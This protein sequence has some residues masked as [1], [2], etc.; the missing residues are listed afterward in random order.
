MTFHWLIYSTFKHQLCKVIGEM[1]KNQPKKEWHAWVIQLVGSWAS[2]R[3]YGIWRSQMT[4]YLCCLFVELECLVFFP[5]SNWSH[6][7]SDASGK[8]KDVF[9]FA[10]GKCLLPLATLTCL[11]S[12][13]SAF[14]DEGHKVTT[15]PHKSFVGISS[16]L[17]QLTALNHHHSGDA[18]RAGAATARHVD[19]QWWLV[20]AWM[21]PNHGEACPPCLANQKGYCGDKGMLLPLTNAYGLNMTPHQLL[22]NQ[23]RAS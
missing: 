17:C 3:I 15:A 18:R 6:W 19:S 14:P 22:L 16:Q 8:W 12:K 21:H 11:I 23:S 10:V 2:A 7:L 1:K 13:A 5:V 20:A 9:Y 4:L